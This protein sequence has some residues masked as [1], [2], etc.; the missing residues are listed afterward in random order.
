MAPKNVLVVYPY[1]QHYRLGVFRAMDSSSKVTYTFVSAL[2]GRRGIKALG[3]DSVANHVETQTLKI[4]PFSWQK[5]LIS[6]LFRRK[7]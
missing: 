3:A 7:L 1:L 6:L 5:G 4:G 2:E